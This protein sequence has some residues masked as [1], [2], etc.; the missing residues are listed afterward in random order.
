MDEKMNW[1]KLEIDEN[2]GT[3]VLVFGAMISGL[4]VSPADRGDEDA[5][6]ELQDK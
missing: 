1:T 4:M 3:R 6:R 5:M 2:T